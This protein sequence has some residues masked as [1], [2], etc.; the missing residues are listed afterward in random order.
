MSDS[1]AS[2]DAAQAIETNLATHR[3]QSLLKD[4]HSDEERKQRLQESERNLGVKIKQIMQ[5]SDSSDEYQLAKTVEKDING[6]LVNHK[7]LRQKGVRRENLY[8]EV[9]ERYFLASESI[10]ALI[11]AN[12]V[13]AHQMESQAHE[14]SAF[15]RTLV[16]AVG[17]LL[18]FSFLI[19]MLGFRF[20]IYSPIRRLHKEIGAFDYSA[21]SLEIGGAKEIQAIH[22]TF[23][24]LA[25]RLIR[26]RD[27]QLMFLSAVAHDL[28]N[29]IG[30]IQM[31]I[32]LL[33]DSSN[34]NQQERVQ[35]LQIIS[36][37]VTQ[38]NGLI[39]DLLD[40][41]RIESGHFELNK[42]P[43]D[44]ISLLSE[45]VQLFSSYSKNHKIN[46]NAKDKSI[47]LAFDRLRMSQVINN[48]LSNAIKYS[49]SG[50]VIHVDV[51]NDKV[52]A[53]I[54]IT[55][56]GIGISPE[57]L[58][59]IFEPFR[60]TKTTQQTIPGVGL[61]LSTALKIIKA[62]GGGLQV[63]SSLEMGSTFEVCLP[64]NFIREERKS[65]EVYNDILS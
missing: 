50:G 4:I 24:D 19:L 65:G 10:K 55:D 63:D 29:P 46:L 6:Y 5:L 57:D 48:L 45:T 18:I 41:T 23:K 56:S 31:S 8:E 43:Q 17:G 39:E 21:P 22:G 47:F 1:I 25:S 33:N 38:L 3:R 13:Q 64:L 28:R 49:P 51:R 58:P 14:Y 16:F 27:Q 11:D 26:Q 44:L 7:L 2:I 53:Y 42:T 35:M 32:E 20:L 60:R 52:N 9:S 34:S 54:S 62:H 37:Q 15:G 40:T 30:A 59:H 12:V 61:G 36:R